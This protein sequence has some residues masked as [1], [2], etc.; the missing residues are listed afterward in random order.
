MFVMS[1]RNARRLDSPGGS[2]VSRVIIE[3]MCVVLVFTT[4][5]NAS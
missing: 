1:A 2:V 3:L 5:S 4:A